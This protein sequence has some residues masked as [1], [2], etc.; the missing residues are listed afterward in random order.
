[1]PPH[2]TPKRPSFRGDRYEIT[3]D[4]GTGFRRRL[5]KYPAGV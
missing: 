1:M 5:G 2:L 4:M 3:N